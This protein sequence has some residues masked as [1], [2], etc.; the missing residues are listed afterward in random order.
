MTSAPAIGFEYRPSHWLRALLWIVGA[1]ALL[2]VAICALPLW[3]KALLIAG[4]LLVTWRTVQRWSKASVSA[5]GWGDADRGWMLHMGSLGEV[6]ATLL[7]FRV[8]GSF[9]LLRFRSE[10]GIQVLLLA[11]DNTDEDI[12]RRMRMRLATVQ[13]DETL[14]RI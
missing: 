3:L 1:L 11:P 14:P 6:P 12:R 8:M 2:A 4:V 10:T 5:A 9:I 13:V 7:S